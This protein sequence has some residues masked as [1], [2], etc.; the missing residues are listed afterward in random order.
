MNISRTI[1]ISCDDCVLQATE[2]CEDCLVSFVVSREPEDAVV[3]DVSEAR[4][5]RLLSAAGLVPQLRHPDVGPQW[6]AV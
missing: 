3:V 5:L 2:A 1:S 4:A 6:S